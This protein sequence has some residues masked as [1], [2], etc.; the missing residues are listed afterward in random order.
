MNIYVHHVAELPTVFS[1]AMRE[2]FAEDRANRSEVDGSKKK[3]GNRVT[4][5]SLTLSRV[6]TRP[7]QVD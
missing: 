1:E 2:F 4:E 7:G 5:C 6:F 3:E